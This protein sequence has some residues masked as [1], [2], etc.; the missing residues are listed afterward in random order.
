MVLMNH[1]N[2]TRDLASRKAATVLEPDG[3]KP[4]LGAIGVALDMDVRWLG[5]ITGEEEATV[6]ADAKDG[7]HGEK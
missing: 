2:D 5:A 6:G 3:I 1:Q 7:R 4:D